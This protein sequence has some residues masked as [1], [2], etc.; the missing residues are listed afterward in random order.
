MTHSPAIARLTA[1]LIAQLEAHCDARARAIATAAL[2]AMRPKPK[3]GRPPKAPQSFPTNPDGHKSI[4]Y[5][6]PMSLIRERRE[7]KER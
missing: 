6:G 4:R 1:D 2:A 7:R 5:F 3:R